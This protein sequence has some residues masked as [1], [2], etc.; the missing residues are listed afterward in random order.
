MNKYTDEQL[1]EFF[2]KGAGVTSVRERVSKNYSETF[3][4]IDVEVDRSGFENRNIDA[5]DEADIL[6]EE[7]MPHCEA[8]A[9]VLND[10]SPEAINALND[11]LHESYINAAGGEAPDETVKSEDQ[12][13]KIMQAIL[14]KLAE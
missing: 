13:M 4:E 9:E 2:T 14:Y 6:M 12:A 11:R 7:L 8:I 5:G 3:D 1:K 10:F